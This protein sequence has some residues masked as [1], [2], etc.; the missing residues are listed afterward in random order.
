MD[1]SLTEDGFS[2]EATFLLAWWPTSQARRRLMKKGPS[3]AP[4]MAAA[5][6][7]GPLARAVIRLHSR[8]PFLGVR[9]A[10]SLDPV[11]SSDGEC[12]VRPGAPS[13]SAPMAAVGNEGMFGLQPQ[14]VY[15]PV[16][17]VK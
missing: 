13:P 2:K 7:D 11:D 1:D 8:T 15:L 16:G 3:T 4:C 5:P 10:A 12:G 9:E 17:I 6:V 14:C